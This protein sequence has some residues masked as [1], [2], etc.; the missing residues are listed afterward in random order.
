MTAR[1]ALAVSSTACRREAT[2]LA[3]SLEIA[4]KLKNYRS[5]DKVLQIGVFPHVAYT[6]PSQ[7]HQAVNSWRPAYCCP[8]QCHVKLQWLHQFA[9]S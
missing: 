1:I 5:F 4:Q 9:L 6:L 2:T 3:S 7:M 8:L